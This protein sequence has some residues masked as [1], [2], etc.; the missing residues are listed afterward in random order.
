MLNRTD[1]V[2][3]VPA[4]V[5]RQKHLTSED[6]RSI[7]SMLFHCSTVPL[8][9]KRILRSFCLLNNDSDLVLL[10]CRSFS[11]KEGKGP[12]EQWNSIGKTVLSV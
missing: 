12:A 5:E 7:F 9:L 6:V 10:A 3:A 11:A 4:L 1:A 8:S 2:P